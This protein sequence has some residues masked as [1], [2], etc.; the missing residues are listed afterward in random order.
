[1]NIFDLIKLLFFKANKDNY[2]ISTETLQQFSPYMLNRWFSFYGKPQAV[3]VN[4][5]L[6]KYASLFEDKYE[7]FIFF[8]NISITVPPRMIKYVKKRREDPKEENITLQIFARNNN[9]SLREVKSYVALFDKKD[10]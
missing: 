6:N 5:I 2:E 7:Q 3:F 10:N 4:E 1:M 9:L 8:K